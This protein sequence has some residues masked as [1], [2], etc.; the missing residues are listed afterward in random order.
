MTIAL[1]A[2][3]TLAAS[4]AAAPERAAGTLQ[5]RATVSAGWQFRNCSATVRCIDF[6][7][8]AVVP[9]LGIVTA[10]YTKTEQTEGCPEITQFRA[11]VLSVEGKGELH[12]SAL[13]PVCG[14][15]APA[16]SSTRLR[17]C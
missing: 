17:R 13:G 16:S 3:A 5:V 4:A 14:N 6:R 8:R 9:G 12:V 15:Y 2:C 11:A 7:A 10:L 1:A